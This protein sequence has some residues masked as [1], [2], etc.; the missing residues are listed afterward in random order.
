[1]FW[2]LFFGM[3]G[4]LSLC[5]FLLMGFLHVDMFLRFLII[6]EMW[7]TLDTP[8]LVPKLICFDVLVEMS[9]GG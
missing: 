8:V 6:V 2:C 7:H 1:M 4:S 9:R 5:F 3:L